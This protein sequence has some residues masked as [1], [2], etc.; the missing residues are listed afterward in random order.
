MGLFS[1]DAAVLAHLS[2]LERKLDLVLS[3]LNLDVPEDD[4]ADI[5]ALAQSG[6]KIEA[7]KL[8]R[9]RTGAGL[10]EAKTAVEAGL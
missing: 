7:I 8:Y 4:L 3:H 10:A 5:R 2:R 1:D 9:E 6:K